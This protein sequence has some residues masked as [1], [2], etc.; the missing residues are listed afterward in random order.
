MLE[1]VYTLPDTYETLDELVMKLST[2]IITFN[3]DVDSDSG[4]LIQLLDQS[5]PD[6]IKFEKLP[7]AGISSI[8]KIS[9]AFERSSTTDH[10]DNAEIKR[11]FWRF[12]MHQLRVR[13]DTLKASSLAREKPNS[14]DCN[15]SLRDQISTLADLAGLI[16]Q[17]DGWERAPGRVEPDSTSV[18]SSLKTDAVPSMVA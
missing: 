5:D 16:D 10:D 18:S 8:K 9:E 1:P 14:N 17:C 11:E 4:C 7:A 6:F 12:L 2:L 15:F 13:A 3:T